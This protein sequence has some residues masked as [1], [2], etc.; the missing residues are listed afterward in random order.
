MKKTVT[1][2]ISGRV[3]YIDDD[4]YQRLSTYLEKIERA[5]ASQESGQEIISDIE[6]RVAEIFEEKIDR[7]SGVVTLNMVEEVISTMGEP[8]EITEEPGVEEE[9][10]QPMSTALVKPR[11][12]LYRDIDNRIFGGVCAGIAAYFNVD[13]LLVR[14]IAVILIFLTSGVMIPAYI[15]LWMALPPAITTAQK[16]EMRGRHI[17]IN[18]IEKSIRD[19]YEEMKHNFTKMKESPTY[20]KGENFFRRMTRRDRTVLIIVAVILGSMFLWNL[21]GF[22]FN[23]VHG[24]IGAFTNLSHG[25]GSTFGHI[26]FPGALP[27]VLVLLVIGLI[28]KTVFKVILYIIA[29]LLLGALALKVFFWIFGGFCLMC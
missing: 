9:H 14:I 22:N 10:A 17:T 11:K 21:P 27:I 20:K 19:E 5:F 13:S 18:N 3:F 7:Q 4:A 1:I 15:I 23:F 28:F 6:S 12:R 29:F 25:V 24:P 26:F 16:L 2:N 8:E